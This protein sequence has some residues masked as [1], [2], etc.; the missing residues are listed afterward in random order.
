MWFW[1][2]NKNRHVPH[3]EALDVKVLAEEAS[4]PRQRLL[5]KGGL[6]AAGSLVGLFLLW[7]GLQWALMQFVFTNQAF[8]IRTIETQTDGVIPAA[9]LRK[10]AQVQV[11]E[12]LMAL[13]LAR[14]KR[15]LEMAP[16]VREAAV[17]RILPGT[18]R[19]RVV[20]R[21]PF[22]QVNAYR[23]RDG[24]ANYSVVAY[25]LDEDGYV[26]APLGRWL[27]GVPMQRPVESLPV[28]YGVSSAELQLGRLVAAAPVQAALHLISAFEG[29]PMFGMDEIV[30][31]DLSTEGVMQVVTAQGSEITF[32]MSNFE[33]QLRRWR[34]IYDYGVSQSKGI[35][36]LDLSV[37]NNVPLRWREDSAP[38]P[39]QPKYLK[40]LRHRKKH[41]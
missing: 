4:A 20:E 16:L 40:S 41:V 26:M 1:S 2:A 25:Y 10:W 19:L 3:D 11:G 17:E 5:I 12:N 24:E 23:M 34:A 29:S 28:L 37:A 14:V 15:D 22:V 35:S 38:P 18:L 13:D 7:Q 21:E 8:A 9:Q 36:A 32:G 33:G 30:R 31:V 27:Q 6:V 39:S